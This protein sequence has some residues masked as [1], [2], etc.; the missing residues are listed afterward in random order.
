MIAD[1]A[2]YHREHS[3]ELGYQQLWITRGKIT[4][5]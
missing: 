5:M 4:L 3:E 2:H 1:T